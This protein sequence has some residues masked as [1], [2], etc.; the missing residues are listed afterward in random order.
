MNLCDE[1][2]HWSENT[3]PHYPL[4][5][6]GCYSIPQ[7]FNP[8]S[9]SLYFLLKCSNVFLLDPRGVLRTMPKHL[10]WSIL[11]KYFPKTLHLRYFT[12]FW[13]CILLIW[14]PLNPM[15]NFNIDLTLSWWRSLL[16][17]GPYHFYMIRTSVMKGLK[18]NFTSLLNVKWIIFNYDSEKN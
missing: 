18:W 5:Y 17:G 10:R 3:V 15:K 14:T 7:K 1:F 4:I 9:W 11:Q 12:G 13:I 16:Y 2:Q 8:T 6:I